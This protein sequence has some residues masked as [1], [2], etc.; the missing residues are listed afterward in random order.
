MTVSTS[1]DQLLSTMHNLSI[2]DSID[3]PTLPTAALGR[4]IPGLESDTHFLS[5]SPKSQLQVHMSNPLS[6]EDADRY[7]YTSKCLYNECINH[8]SNIHPTSSAPETFF[9]GPVECAE[10]TEVV[11]DK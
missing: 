11:S 5:Q 1:L 10:V 6:Y 7:T 4:N 2:C 8:P 3:H 9:P